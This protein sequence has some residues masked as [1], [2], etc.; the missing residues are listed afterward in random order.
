LRFGTVIYLN[1]F[2]RTLFIISALLIL[3]PAVCCQE[4][5]Y[6]AALYSNIALS[7]LGAF[8]ILSRVW[9]VLCASMIAA[10]AFL[11]PV[12]AVCPVCIAAIVVLLLC[13]LLFSRLLFTCLS[14]PTVQMLVVLQRVVII[15]L[16]YLYHLLR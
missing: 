2:T 3:L 7:I 14:P 5:H 11:L 15:V 8:L 16:L 10:T 9:Q 4:V 12:R 1:L 13:A 6:G